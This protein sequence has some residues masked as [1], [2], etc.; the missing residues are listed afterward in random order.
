MMLRAKAVLLGLVVGVVGCGAD[1]APLASSAMQV[2]KNTAVDLPPVL[3]EH[4]SGTSFA[5]RVVAAKGMVALSA[6]EE[7]AVY[8]YE[9]RARGR[10]EL[11]AIVPAPEPFGWTLFGSGL[12]LDAGRLVVGEP[13]TMDG[14]RVHVYRRTLHGGWL[15]VVFEP[16][17]R[18]CP[19]AF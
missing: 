2:S 11:G 16:A 7:S 5:R 8:V 18:F 4:P 9:E 1:E 6:S 17:E 15:L 12:A 3:I 19:I 13:L 10:W 14:G